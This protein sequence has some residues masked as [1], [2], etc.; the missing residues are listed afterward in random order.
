MLELKNDVSCICSN[1][2]Y[3]CT[4][5]VITVVWCTD[6]LH[7]YTV[8]THHHRRDAASYRAAMAIYTLPCHADGGGG[9]RR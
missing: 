9:N 6:S 8:G 2:H 4:Y 7:I 1:C 3:Y 5:I